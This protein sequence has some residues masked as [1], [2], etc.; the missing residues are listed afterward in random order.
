M[1]CPRCGSKMQGEVLT[2]IPPMNIHRCINC[3][4]MK[5]DNYSKNNKA[6]EKINDK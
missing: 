3:G 6:L 2:C 1:K 5:K 4:Y